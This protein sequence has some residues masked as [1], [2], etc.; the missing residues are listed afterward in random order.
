MQFLF[1]MQ[2]KI[3]QKIRRS[4]H[5][6]PG[7]KI[8]YYQPNLATDAANQT[9]LALAFSIYVLT[10]P[11]EYLSLPIKHQLRYPQN[12][13]LSHAYLTYE[14]RWN[15]L[16]CFSTASRTFDSICLCSSDYGKPLMT[17]I[18]AITF[19][20]ATRLLAQNSLNNEVLLILF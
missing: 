3:I 6:Y 19:E 9:N 11:R 14:S 15:L 2:L 17:V 18:V 8:S 1:Q 7:P 4:S 12:N 5:H 10:L 20:W 16:A 13:L